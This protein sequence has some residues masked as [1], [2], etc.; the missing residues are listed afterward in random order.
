MDITY[1]STYYDY[2]HFQNDLHHQIRD[3]AIGQFNSARKMGGDELSRSYRSKLN[4]EIEVCLC[5]VSNC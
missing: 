2:F 1:Y 3:L 5:M 4:E